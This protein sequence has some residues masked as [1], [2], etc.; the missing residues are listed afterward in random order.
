MDMGRILSS[1]LMR[2]ERQFIAN[3]II[4]YMFSF[5]A[6]DKRLPPPTS[7][8]FCGLG[9]DAKDQGSPPFPLLPPPRIEVLIYLISTVNLLLSATRSPAQSEELCVVS[10]WSLLFMWLGGKTTHLLSIVKLSSPSGP[11][12]LCHTYLGKCFFCAGFLVWAGAH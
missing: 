8:Q 9:K 4:R 12:E 10:F 5:G 1:W 6:R 3:S 7:P 2:M 11:W